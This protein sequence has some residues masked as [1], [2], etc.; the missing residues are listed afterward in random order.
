[1]P[2]FR[3]SVLTQRLANPALGEL[4]LAHDALGIDPQ[5]HVHAVPGPLGYLGRVDAAVQPRRQA[6]VPEVRDFREWLE[7][8]GRR[9]S[10]MT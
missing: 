1:V 4:V 7:V 3:P 9:S 5:Q 2:N 10:S 6:G 8:A